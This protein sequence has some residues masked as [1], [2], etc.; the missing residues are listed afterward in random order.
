MSGFA[1][2]P[3]LL[4]VLR[5]AWAMTG[6]EAG[7]VGGAFFFGYMVSVP[8]LSG[9][10]DRVDAKRVFALSCVL[11]SV[12]ALGFGRLASG[13]WSGVFW[14]ALSGAGLA[15]TYMPGLKALTDRVTGPK[16]SRYVSF[17]TATF[18]VG[19]SF[20]L[21]LAGWLDARLGWA[22][23]FQ[24][25][26]LFPLMAAP[27]VLWGL[28]AKPPPASGAPW[29]PRFGGVWADAGTRTYIV[30]YAVH[31]WELFGLRSWQ[32]AF[33]TFAFGL[34]AM[35]AWVSPTE[36]AAVLNLLGLPASI[37]G[38]EMAGRIGRQRW[39][40][41]M[42]LSAGALSWLVGM[43]AALPWVITLLAMAVY[44]VTV[45]ADSAS[46]TAGLVAASDPARRGAAMALYSLG[47]F[48]A[49]FVSPVVFGAV[50][51]AFGGN[52]S[53][54]AWSMGLGVLGLGGLVM[55][56]RLRVRLARG[57]G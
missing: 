29:W 30:G 38:N 49:G 4:P 47:G 33:F 50:L 23:T 27:L 54:L 9:L 3:A 11:A 56:W 24:A 34:G 15:G 36:A 13:V 1:T 28:S 8:L 53:L 35:Q 21:L 26:A 41:A 6:A 22:L 32:V 10:T 40:A 31:C 19:T 55:G 42:M 12:G 57:Q 20:S 5:E 7:L 14:Q 51:D 17:Y 44:N 48:G 25:L 16:Q 39:I 46:L 18:G 45:M 2:Y 52:Q 37:L 43:T